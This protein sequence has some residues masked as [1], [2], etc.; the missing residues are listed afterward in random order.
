MLVSQLLLN[1]QFYILCY[2]FGNI[3]YMYT[4]LNSQKQLMGS[5][6]VIQLEYI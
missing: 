1:V 4:H 5:L 2:S 3:S 6:L